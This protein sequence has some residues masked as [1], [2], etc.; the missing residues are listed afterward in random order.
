MNFS[1]KTILY[2]DDDADDR[3]L[4]QQVMGKVAP[5]AKVVFAE[6]GLTGLDL[7]NKMKKNK[8]T[9]CLIILDL[10][11]PYM[12]GQETF[13]SIKGDTELRGIPLVIFTSGEK[14]SDKAWFSEKGIAYFTKPIDFTAMEHI[15]S[16]MAKLC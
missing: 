1:D 11:M 8:E 10:N 14:P 2:V 6:N 16:R 13:K 7:L 4:L 15:V 9:P 3:E 12:N 5:E